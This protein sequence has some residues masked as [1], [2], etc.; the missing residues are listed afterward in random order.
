MGFCLIE[1]LLL[2]QSPLF[3]PSD[4]VFINS[5]EVFHVLDSSLCAYRRQIIKSGTG[6]WFYCLVVIH[7]VNRSYCG[8]VVEQH[9]CYVY[10]VWKVWEDPIE[11]HCR[12][13]KQTEANLCEPTPAEN[14]MRKEIFQAQLFIQFELWAET[15][16]SSGL[17]MC[18][19]ISS[20]PLEVDSISRS[21]A[22]S[23]GSDW[24]FR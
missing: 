16:P 2:A 24:I 9:W 8:F 21:F 14:K 3:T 23:F 17:C 4:K 12:L 10:S 1:N 15:N 20:G 6:S 13:W 19:S 22:A 18:S 7:A 11:Q 5:A